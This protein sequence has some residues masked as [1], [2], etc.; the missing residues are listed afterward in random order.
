MSIFDLYDGDYFFM[1]KL[2]GKTDRESERAK[3]KI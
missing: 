3:G 1:G 2:V